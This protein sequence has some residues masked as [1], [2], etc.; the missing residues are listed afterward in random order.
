M[1][2][3]LKAPHTAPLGPSPLRHLG[4][5]LAALAL[6]YGGARAYAQLPCWGIAALAVTAA[7]P[8]WT[9]RTANALFHRRLL[10]DGVAVPDGA[11]RRWLWRGWLMQALGAVT[12]IILA[13]ALL[14]AASLLPAEHWAVLALDV[15]LLSLLAEPVRRRV[16]RQVRPEHAALITRRWPLMALN[17]SILA[18]AFLVIDFA[19]VGA[20][21]TRALGWS[22]VAEQAFAEAAGGARCPPAGWAAGTLAAVAALTWHASQLV[23]PT[24]PDEAL[25]MTAWLLFLAGAGLLAWLFTTLLLGVLAL[26]EHGRVDNGDGGGSGP[27]S[28]SASGTAWTAF[29]Y[30]ILLLAI[31]YLYAS[32][33]LRDFDPSVLGQGARELVEI[34]NP[35]RLDPARQALLGELDA[36]LAAARAK[37][38]GAADQDIEAGVDVLFAKVE[39]GADAYLDWYFSVI[40]EYQRLGAAAVGDL[41]GLM[42]DASERLLFEETGF[43]AGLQA[44][45]AEIDAATRARLA[46]TAAAAGRQVLQAA[47]AEAGACRVDGIDLAALDNVGADFER[48][49]LRAS[50]AAGSGAAAALTVKLLAKKTGAAVA[51]KLAAKQ[52]V[53]AAAALGGKLAAK[54]G[55]SALVSGLGAAALCAPGGPLAIACGIGGAA[56]T[57][58]AVDKALVEID[59]VR[60][61]DAMRADLLAVLEEQRGM[62]AAALK[63]QQAARIDAGLLRLQ[64]S[65]G[66]DFVPLRDGL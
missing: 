46:D 35:C 18:A 16:A 17:L 54:K 59:E 30:T 24:L 28:R 4:W 40:G 34:A 3:A 23:I 39:E 21:D 29:V 58:L 65:L 33:K 52:G 47:G 53:K 43:D 13:L 27:G 15:L 7:W 26:T 61:R 38:I 8:I 1:S 6:L 48:D 9:Y 36:T 57:W 32:M 2:D 37:A 56:V 5:M 63:A 12:A 19:V 55:G 51:G 66:R 11:A 64:Q 44:L 14:A 41:G 31:P 50:T 42:A 49:A 45:W 20:P 22:D 62:L 10:L 60:L 25:T